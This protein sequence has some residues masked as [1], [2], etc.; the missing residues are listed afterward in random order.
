MGEVENNRKAVA[1]SILTMVEHARSE[2]V[3]GIY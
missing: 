2:N 1:E 3:R